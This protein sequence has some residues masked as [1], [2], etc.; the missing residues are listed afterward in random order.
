[1]CEEVPMPKYSILIPAFNVEQ[2]IEKC[3]QSVLNQTYSDW[4]AIIVD[5]GSND[6]TFNV[7][8]SFALNDQRF[9]LIQ[10]KFNEGLH[11]ARRS[12]ALTSS[13]EYILFLDSDDELEPRL[14]ELL[15]YFVKN[16]DADMV[17]YGLTAIPETDADEMFAH[18]YEEMFNA[19]NGDLYD[20]DILDASFSYNLQ[21]WIPWN[22]HTTLYRGDL[23]RKSFREMCAERLN[24][25][26]DAFEYLVFCTHATSSLSLVELHGLRYHIGRGI[27][28]RSKIS[29]EKF[30]K[31]QKAAHDVVLAIDEFAKTK[32]EL[33]I[34]KAAEW[35]KWRAQNIVLDDYQTRLLK[36]DLE[37]CMLA[38]C[39]TWGVNSAIEM[40]LS[41]IEPRAG[42]FDHHEMYP[43]QEDSINIWKPIYTKIR[44]NYISDISLAKRID[45][46]DATLARIEHRELVRKY[47]EQQRIQE[48]QRQAL[49]QAKESRR[50]FKKGTIMRTVLD[51]F[52]PEKSTIRNILRTLFTSLRNIARK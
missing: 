30:I 13:G 26:E 11:A 23:V 7:A 35:V 42:W 3:L 31:D 19:T 47:N 6:N 48:A 34:Q 5:D 4:E 39:D 10:K 51:T 25:L 52:F 29:S 44:T 38:I 9:H 41:L 15:D 24:K 32:R 16:N 28:G 8:N 45:T 12:A 21:Y 18:K 50:I 40:L 43:P 33:R 2:Y 22:V 46:L 17:R 37:Q 49:E 27:S 1:M 36:A 20:G 14:I